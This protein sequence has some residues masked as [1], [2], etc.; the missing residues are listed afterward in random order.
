MT[1]DLI[2]GI[3]PAA[4]E[5]LHRQA[6]SGIRAAILEGRIG[7]GIRVPSSRALAETLGLARNTVTGA[8]N[9]LL[10]EG[11]LETRHVVGTH[12]VAGGA[13]LRRA[14]P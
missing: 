3:D 2:V 12:D 11:Y 14:R 5:P 1:V 6:Y 8:Y 4:A 9:Q 10:A 13:A 7:P